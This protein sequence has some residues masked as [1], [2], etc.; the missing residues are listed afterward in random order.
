MIRVVLDTNILVSALLQPQG[1]PA[2]TFLITLAGTTAQLCVSGD[3]YAEYEEV[4][5]RPKFKRD[6]VVIES[7]L[8]AIRQ[9]GFWVKPTEKVRACTDPDDDIFLECAQ[10]ARAHYLVTGNQKDFPVKWADTQVVTAR[11]FLDA[12][13]ETRE[14]PR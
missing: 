11:Q 14:E 9:N 3:V 13:A 2:R 12:V 8:R 1:L 10:A 7:A 4:I 5:R 6:E